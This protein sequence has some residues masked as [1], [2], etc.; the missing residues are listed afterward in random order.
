MEKTVVLV[1]PDAFQRGLVGR[2]VARF[3]RKG[4]KLIG[5]KMIKIS[6]ELAKEHYAHL[7]DK[8]FYPGLEKFMTSDPILVFVVEGQEAIEVVRKIVGVTNS[9]K[10]EAGTVR[11]DFSMSTGRNTI[12]A[13]DSQETAQKELARFFKPEELFEYDLK[14]WDYLYA[15]DEKE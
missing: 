3:E 8:P 2:I 7:V 1:K 14:V 4:L 13:S 10:A 6:P 11:G 9:R 15:E 5:M 12:H